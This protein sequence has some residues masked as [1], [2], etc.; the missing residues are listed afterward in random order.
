MRSLLARRATLL[1]T[2]AVLGV[3]LLA[4]IPI[5]SWR[6][7]YSVVLPLP[8]P[9]HSA[10][11]TIDEGLACTIKLS[12]F[13]GASPINE[14]VSLNADTEPEAV[15]I[16]LDRKARE[17]CMTTATMVKVGKTDEC[18]LKIVRE[19]DQHI[20]ATNSFMGAES[21]VFNKSDQTMMWS[22]SAIFLGITSES[23]YLEC[24]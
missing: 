17:I 6:S 7:S 1:A 23:H 2:G 10:F 22:R 21:V 3:G 20:I 14:N 5:G 16:R 9:Q 19:T 12:S 4:L 15:S 13:I 24:K 11:R 8:K 18:G